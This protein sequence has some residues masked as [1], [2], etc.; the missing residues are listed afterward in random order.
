MP[1]DDP[2]ADAAHLLAGAR[3]ADAQGRSNDAETLAR[4]LLT[5]EPDNIG[6][7][8]VLG[9]VL[10][11]QFRLQEASNLLEGVAREDATCFESRL[12]L[13]RMARKN[14]RIDVSLEYGGAALALQPRS[15]EALVNMG[16]SL[17]DA[18]EF[19]GAAELLR[20]A[21]DVTPN[22]AG[23]LLHLGIAEQNGG[24][25]SEARAAYQRALELDPRLAEAH[26]GLGKVSLAT[27][28][29]ADA[30]TSARQALML[31]SKSVA[32]HH[33]LLEAL[34]EGNRAEEAHDQALLFVAACPRDTGAA[35]LLARCLLALGKTEEAH[36]TLV[37]SID[38]QPAQGTAYCLIAQSRKFGAGD[39]ALIGNMEATLAG[40]NLNLH[41]E[42]CL[43]YGLGKAY[44]DLGRFGDAMAQFDAANRLAYMLKFGDRV[45]DR[46]VYA[47]QIQRMIDTFDANFMERY[48][49]IGDPVETPIFVVGMMRSGATLVEQILSSHPDIGA[50]GE[51]RFWQAHGHEAASAGGEELNVERLR[52]LSASYL[53]GL[54]RFGANG[55]RV[56]DKFP[57]NYGQLGLLHIAYPNARIV[58]I[59]RHPVDTCLSIYT[60]PNSAPNAFCNNRENIVFGY[61]EYLRLMAH[62]R[63]VLPR[64]R[65]LEVDYEALIRDS[66]AETRRLVEFCGLPWS[67]DCLQ[68]EAS[69][70]AVWTPSAV[71][72]RKAIYNTSIGRW[73]LYREWLGAFAE[74]LDLPA[75]PA[76]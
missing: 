31:N 45:L 30:A 37:R 52:E 62:W 12:W 26:V 48:A 75:T 73:E 50:G 4:Q 70:H 27:A 19:E 59:R 49:D 58:H 64:D 39:Q 33:L 15:P 38:M 74:L 35:A 40:A 54:A 56:T 32:A 61:R 1:V 28:D 10:A 63:T 8:R 69:T 57:G 25:L 36:S 34:L 23:V 20:Q 17:I 16:L 29:V 9:V 51:Q 44:E 7:R 47:G 60:T 5:S 71:Q 68:H 22:A 65:L 21:A 13:S 42:S 6:A 2:K 24:R 55:S 53:D 41:E 72:V 3:A 43:R 67:D 66:E 11:K 46:T 18:H 14:G 76:P